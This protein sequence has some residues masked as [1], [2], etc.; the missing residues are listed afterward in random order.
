MFDKQTA[1]KELINSSLPPILLLL[2][3]QFSTSSLTS[4]CLAL[5]LRLASPLHLYLHPSPS[6]LIHLAWPT[7]SGS[8]SSNMT[9]ASFSP[10]K[11]EQ[12]AKVSKRIL[13]SQLQA[14][15]PH[16][17]LHYSENQ[18]HQEG[19]VPHNTNPIYHQAG[20]NVPSSTA[21]FC[22]YHWCCLDEFAS[23]ERN[24]G[25]RR[26]TKGFHFHRSH[27]VLICLWHQCGPTPNQNILHSL[28]TVGPTL[29][30]SPH[31]IKPASSDLHFVFRRISLGPEEGA[32]PL[33]SHQVVL[34]LNYRSGY[35]KFTKS[36]LKQEEKQAKRKQKWAV[37][38]AEE[39]RRN[40]E[41][42]LKRV[43]V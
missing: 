18:Q 28:F 22:I 26:H 38:E 21:A 35:S 4:F 30:S 37:R 32:W 9:S 7:I 1:P 11:A 3:P 23:E 16:P 40:K 13:S 14:L 15:F 29:A 5:S 19:K 17:P 31:F 43:F 6:S 39:T 34:C 33:R 12:G 41:R 42:K 36:S 10:E 2:F 24:C 25:F 27:T 8:P 20:E